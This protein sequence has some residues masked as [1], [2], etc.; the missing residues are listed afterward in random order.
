[1][2][3]SLYGEGPTRLYSHGN[4]TSLEQL[5][6]EKI[7]QTR[8]NPSEDFQRI[9][10]WDSKY[11][12]SQ[13]KIHTKLFSKIDSEQSEFPE[14]LPP[15]AFHPALQKTSQKHCKDMVENNY[16]SNLNRKRKSPTDRAKIEGYRFGVAE[17]IFGLGAEFDQDLEDAHFYFVLDFQFNSR[18]KGL[19]NR[20]NILNPNFNEIGIGIEGNRES[21]KICQTFGRDF[22]VVYLTGVIYEDKNQNGKYDV[23]EGLEGVEVIPEYGDYF[24]ITSY[25]G[26]Y[27]IPF[28]VTDE[29][30]LEIPIKVTNV[31]WSSEHQEADQN[32]RKEYSQD[33]KNWEWLEFL[34]TFKGGK[35]KHPRVNPVRMIKPTKISYK[36]IQSEGLIWDGPKDI[37]FIL[38]SNHKLDLV[39]PVDSD[40]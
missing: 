5:F 28:Y 18:K 30:K 22:Q 11:T 19:P 25:S 29:R 1:M 35:L 34:V 27:A 23:G 36:L 17:N 38:G 7:N 32:F 31:K 24:T 9:L 8:I 15:L 14:K 37:P 4:P 16:F 21:G 39:L 33:R 26:G 2:G 13:K 10:N 20:R 12:R 3:T 6:L 40:K